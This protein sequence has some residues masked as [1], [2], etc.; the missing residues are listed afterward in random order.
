MGKQALQKSVE[1]RI[2]EWLK[3]PLDPETRNEIKALMENHPEKANEVFSQGLSFGTAGMRGIMGVGS[4]QLNIYTIRQATQGLANYIL[5][6]KPTPSPSVIISY[7]CRNHSKEFAIETARVLAGN[8]IKAYIYKELRPTPMASWGTRH[9]GCAAGVMI[10]ASHNPAAYNG[11]KVYWKDGAQVT[12]PHDTGIMQEVAKVEHFD[13]IKLAKETDPLIVWLGK[14]ADE[15]YLAE[16]QK[17]AITPHADQEKGSWLKVLYSPLYGAGRPIIPE[18]LKRAGFTSLELVKGQEGPNGNFPGMPH[19]DPASREA[20]KVGNELLLKQQ[21]D[22][23]LFSDPDSDRLGVSIF[24]EKE[25]YSF[26]GNEMGCLLLDFILETKK[27]LPKNS[28]G[29]TSIVSSPLFRTMLEKHHLTC[30]EVLTGFK[31]I[32]EK[33]HLWETEKD[34]FHY[35]FG[36]EESMGYLYGTHSRDKDATVAALLVAEMALHAKKQGKTLLHKLYELYAQY[37]IYREIT[38]SIDCKEG[39]ERMLQIMARLRQTPPTHLGKRKVVRS[40]DLMKPNAELPKSNV[41]IF[42]LE[43]QS[44][45]IVRPSGTEPQ[46]KIYGQ[47]KKTNAKY[48]TKN[49]IDAVEKELQKLLEEAKQNFLQ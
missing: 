41:L 28:A 18:A 37:G 3:A 46:I 49:E 31:Y 13:A 25:I 22:I 38:L 27:Q 1:E 45:V 34:T 7:D 16:I 19:P 4:N 35:L 30:F 20:Q 47:M 33:I 39:M 12:A 5:Q 44:R 42:E 15:A 17:L 14:E 24:H 21:G 48:I 26:T 2:K 32:G 43:D 23:C 29:V 8:K 9:Y 11:Y 10:T 6:K 40:I 36:F